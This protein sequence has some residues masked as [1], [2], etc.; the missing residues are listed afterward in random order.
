TGDRQARLAREARAAAALN[1]P[2]IATVYALEEIEGRWCIASEYVAGPTLRDAMAEGDRGV[3]AARAALRVLAAAVGAAHA[4]GI[5]HRDL[6][7]ENIVRAADGT[8]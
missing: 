2:N 6:K 3:A 8:L 1:H 5:V 7:P 4:R